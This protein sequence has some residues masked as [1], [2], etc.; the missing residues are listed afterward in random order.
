MRV[1]RMAAFVRMSIRM[2]VLMHVVESRAV[3]A[4]LSVAVAVTLR[5]HLPLLYPR[6]LLPH[7]HP[8]C[9]WAV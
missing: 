7:D 6:F 4:P 3:C 5:S 8:L 9:Y 1:R 2:P